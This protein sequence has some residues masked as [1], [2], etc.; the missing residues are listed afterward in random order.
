MKFKNIEEFMT[1]VGKLP[2][3]DD[4]IEED[5]MKRLRLDY[6]INRMNEIFGEGNW[7]I[8]N[9][10]KGELKNEQGHSFGNTCVLSVTYKHPV[11]GH[12]LAREGVSETGGEIDNNIIGRAFLNAI[13]SIGG[14]FG[15]FL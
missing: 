2:P 12:L 14:T 11:A 3:E 15:R 4:I 13:S 9:I 10:R 7:N 8:E 1:E 5:G 6:A